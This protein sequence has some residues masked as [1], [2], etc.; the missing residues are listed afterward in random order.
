[1]MANAAKNVDNEV[2]DGTVSTVI[3]T[4]G[5]LARCKELLVGKRVRP[6]TLV[7]GCGTALAESLRVL[8]EQAITIKIDDRDSLEKV[9]KTSLSRKMSSKDREHIAKIVV[10]AVLRVAEKTDSGY[11]VDLKNIDIRTRIGGWITDSRLIDGIAFYKEKPHPDM[12]STVKDAKIAVLENDLTIY[13]KAGPKMLRSFFEINAPDKINIYPQ[14]NLHVLKDMVDNIVNVGA[15]VVIVEKGV[16]LDVLGALARRRILVIRR[17]DPDGLERVAKT[18]G[19][20]A[21]DARFLKPEHLGYAQLVE[22]RNFNGQPWFFIEGCR[23]PKSAT[24]LIRGSDDFSLNEN[25]RCIRD[26]LKVIRCVLT[27]PRVL[28]GGGAVEM[29]LS[30]KLKRLA[31]RL[32]G[33]ERLVTEAF[34]EALESIPATLAENSGADLIDS[35]TELRSAHAK[36]RRSIGFDVHNR[37]PTNMAQKGVYDP[38]LVKRQILES[39]TETAIAILRID[40]YIAGRKLTKPE[41]YRKKREKKTSP[42]QVRKLEREY[43]IHDS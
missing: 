10:E 29:E 11:E 19:A 21:V 35:V 27:D 8:E 25:E 39:A 36:G 5:I 43:G 33:R 14:L 16:S 42:E 4:A 32:K 34:S 3:L 6:D 13:Y 18:V 17:F 24:I 7:K 38:L 41:Y 9:A 40:D 1:L 15:N 23:N 22:E 37:H 31:R 12:P 30:L 28:V 2:G 26:A 20:Q